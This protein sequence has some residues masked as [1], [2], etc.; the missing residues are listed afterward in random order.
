MITADPL[1]GSRPEYQLPNRSPPKRTRRSTPSARTPRS[2]TTSQSSTSSHVT[3]VDTAGRS[4][5]RPA[6]STPVTW[7]EVEDCEVV[8]DLGVLADG[9]LRRVRLG[10][11]LFGS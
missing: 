3:G 9:V 11:D 5:E 10:G 4:R 8:E 1:V 7:D 2:S 6:V